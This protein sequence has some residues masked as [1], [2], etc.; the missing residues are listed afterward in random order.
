MTKQNDIVE[1]H[2]TV[3]NTESLLRQ[4][5]IWSSGVRVPTRLS[6]GTGALYG[7]LKKNALK[8]LST[9]TDYEISC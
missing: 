2:H 3:D 6:L 5:G 8:K 4:D 1:N 9:F 7:V